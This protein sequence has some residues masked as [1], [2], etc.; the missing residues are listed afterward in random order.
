MK[1]WKVSLISYFSEHR[2]NLFSK[3]M[4]FCEHFIEWKCS[5]QALKSRHKTDHCKVTN[6]ET[7]VI[8]LDKV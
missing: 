4:D 1:D 7:I 2:N 3:M 6:P 5:W 8:I